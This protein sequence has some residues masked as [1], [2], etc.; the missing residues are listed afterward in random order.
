[1]DTL[2]Q[3]P[4]RLDLLIGKVNNRAMNLIVVFVLQYS[5]TKQNPLDWT[6]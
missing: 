6:H 4:K 3:D 2:N 1:M 5:D